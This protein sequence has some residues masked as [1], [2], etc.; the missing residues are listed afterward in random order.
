MPGVDAVEV[1]M[2]GATS[3]RSVV[4]AEYVPGIVQEYNTALTQVFGIALVM[5]CLTTLGSLVVEWR[6]AKGRKI[7]VGT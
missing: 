7:E 4:P 1:A 5:A 6:S 3:F 2:A